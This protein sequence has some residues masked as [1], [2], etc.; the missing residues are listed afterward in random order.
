MHRRV[1]TLIV[2]M[3]MGVVGR[4]TAQQ[5]EA[6]KVN[7]WSNSKTADRKT[8]FV[9]KPGKNIT[10]TVKADRAEKYVWLV[11][12]TIREGANAE[13]FKWTVPNKKGMW[14]ICVKTTNK[15]REE[16]AK[17]DAAV[18]K[19]RFKPRTTRRGRK[20]DFSSFIQQ[21]MDLN[22][23]PFESRAEW[24]IA[25]S[26][27][28]VK[29]GE[30][31]RKAIDSLPA[32]GGVVE[33]AP[34]VHDVRETIRITRSNVVVCGTR[35]SEVK[36]HD[37]VRRVF[38]I[39]N[40]R[41]KNDAIG[42]TFGKLENLVFRGFKVTSSFT[43][44][45]G[46]VIVA[47]N[48]DNLTVE[49]IENSSYLGRILV[50]NPLARGG[51]KVRSRNVIVRNC[52]GH[53]SA[54][55]IYHSNPVYVVNNVF[56]DD[57]RPCWG[58]HID[59]GNRDIHVV[60]NYVNNCGCNGSLVMDVGGPYNVRD[61]EVVNASQ[62]GIYMEASVHDAII[63]NNTIRGARPYG[64]F[65]AGI[66]AKPQG[67]LHNV[68]IMNNRIYD[69]KGFGIYMTDIGYG[70]S[71]GS[72]ADI[73]NNV[74]Y[75]NSGDGIVI[76]SKHYS[77]LNVSNNIIANNKGCGVSCM[78]GKIT[79]SN[80]DV[81]NN[82]KGNY[83]KCTAGLGD[84]SKDPLFADPSKGDFHLKSQAGRWDTKTRKWVKDKEQSPCIDAG[85]PKADCS[86][87]PSPNR[88]RVNIGAY[89]NTAEASKSS[90]E[91]TKAQPGISRRMY[92][93][94]TSPSEVR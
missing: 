87:E 40:E 80:N 23:Y 64:R 32:E 3:A 53:H 43:K 26:L 46:A 69:C 86:R 31:I 78:D 48:V 17:K 36:A 65:C 33:L 62:R 22:V 73:I 93:T 15:A 76:K 84:F 52:I 75:N 27:I 74:I 56:K 81:W 21:V 55:S 47:W 63:I 8:V 24:I 66:M 77:F 5:P 16:W 91:E 14:K 94:V 35:K 4:A 25:T 54:M 71:P 39:P 29:P 2:A 72:N 88:N 1:V 18:W 10:F 7:S 6:P 67:A 38:I 82:T 92:P 57:P 49:D 45:G 50:T 70:V 89:G 60:G 12:K 28:V 44:R 9:V 85:D 61:N 83:N 79:L 41:P 20:I 58:L 13:S 19:D 51:V 34:G 42:A 90:R 68:L 59:T 30:S 11:D 37:G